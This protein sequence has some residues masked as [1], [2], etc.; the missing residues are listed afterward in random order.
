MENYVLNI[1][2]EASTRF[3]TLKERYYEDGMLRTEEVIDRV[4]DELTY[5]TERARIR[6][7][8][9]KV[10]TALTGEETIVVWFSVLPQHEW[11]LMESLDYLSDELSQDCIAM[12]NV[13]TGQG[14][15]IGPYDTVWGEFNLNYFI[16]PPDAVFGD[17]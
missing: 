3:T 12:Y 7:F 13:S 4:L 16:L 15:L 14:D 6:N 1:G 17:A 10:D 8:G 9:Y 5:I 2:R 11:R